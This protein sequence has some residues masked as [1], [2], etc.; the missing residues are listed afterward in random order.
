MVEIERYR[1]VG[2][3]L[4]FL[5]PFPKT[6]GRVELFV[7]TMP[8]HWVREA[9]GLGVSALYLGILL[10][11]LAGLRKT[12]K[13]LRVSNVFTNQWGVSRYAKSRGLKA[14][15]GARIHCCRSNRPQQPGHH[16]QAGEAGTQNQIKGAPDRAA[17]PQIAADF[18]G[19]QTTSCRQEVFGRFSGTRLL[20]NSLVILGIFLISFAWTA[21]GRQIGELKSTT[22]PE[23]KSRRMQR[24]CGDDVGGK[25][26]PVKL[27]GRTA[28]AKRLNAL[29]ASISEPDI[30]A[31]SLRRLAATLI[32]ESENLTAKQ[33]K[34][35]GIDADAL[36]RIANALTRTLAALNEMQPPKKYWTSQEEQEG[37]AERRAYLDALSID[38]LHELRATVA[39]TAPSIRTPP[40]VPDHLSDEALARARA[41]ALDVYEERVLLSRASSQ[42]DEGQGEADLESICMASLE[43]VF[44]L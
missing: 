40:S 10:W 19:R 12:T 22:H 8:L 13:L 1:T 9:S 38:E 35:E 5:P 3:A 16:H 34:G 44:G 4:P 30:Q 31:A 25:R 37:I 21:I 11:H 26:A 6:E 41:R 43:K 20:A 42:E 32:V 7:R 28:D 2:A 33:T 23:E 15:E 39:G 24:V 27:D 14:L 29:I 18:S 17:R 36:V